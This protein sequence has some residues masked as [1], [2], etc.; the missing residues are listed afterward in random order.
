MKKLFAIIACVLLLG[1]TSCNQA[2]DNSK[3][4]DNPSAE[5]KTLF[6]LDLVDSGSII[7]EYDANAKE[8]Y[9]IKTATDKK[10]SL[11]VYTTAIDEKVN[12]VKT[13]IDYF[14]VNLLRFESTITSDEVSAINSSFYKEEILKAD[15]FG[16]EKL[17]ANSIQYNVNVESSVVENIKAGQKGYKLSAIYLPVKV[18][19]VRS[20][21]TVL[22]VYMM[23][24]LY[25]EIYKD[26]SASFDGITDLTTAFA[27]EN[28]YI[29]KA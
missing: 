10:D 6:K 8:Y 15:S 2:Q 24:P 16:L 20:G 5:L 23:L 3:R 1:L 18:N 12:D 11:F 4:T 21:A 13:Q 22:D 27:F 9:T 14:T 28:A 29:V 25:A 26:E 19:H 17:N 7:N